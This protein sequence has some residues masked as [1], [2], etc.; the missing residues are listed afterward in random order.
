[1]GC[2]DGSDL[3]ST[4]FD[5]FIMRADGAL[6]QKLSDDWRYE[7]GPVFVEISKK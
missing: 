1:M 3:N 2:F 7:Q 6:S 5:I 4:W